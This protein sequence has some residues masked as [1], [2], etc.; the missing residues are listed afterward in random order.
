MPW[1]WAML[2]MAT[3]AGLLVVFRICLKQGGHAHESPCQPAPVPGPTG[4]G[5]AGGFSCGVYGDRLE[6]LRRGADGLLG[7]ADGAAE[8]EAAG[9]PELFAPPGE[10]GAARLARGLAR[11][12]VGAAGTEAL[13]RLHD[14]ATGPRQLA[15]LIAADPVLTG[16][17]LKIV[18]SPLFGLRAAVT[19]LSQAIGVMGLANLRMLLFGEFLE[20][21]GAG[22]GLPAALRRELWLHLGATAALARR[23]AP[24]FPGLDA[25]ML[26]TAGLMHDIG[27][28]VLFGAD[29]GV[30]SG[31]VHHAVAGEAACAAFD[32]PLPIRQ[33]VLL[34][35]APVCLDLEDLDAGMAGIRVAVALAV[36]DGLAHC[37]EAGEA[38]GE[39]ALSPLRASYR[40]L[41]RESALRQCLAAPELLFEVARLRA[42]L[43][44]A[45]A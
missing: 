44:L 22:A 32:L 26:F 17:V 39:V 35:H 1:T 43:R 10:E 4:D 24:A 15:D 5:E 33:G 18:N 38:G 23:I 40:P 25:G 28:L 29:C 16:R 3:A 27:R 6:R 13:R 30:G 41:V 20:S 19:H 42:M 12:R 31:G 21:A 7:G 14:P 2:G 9:D 34:H 45:A 36:A 8:A 37:L 11:L